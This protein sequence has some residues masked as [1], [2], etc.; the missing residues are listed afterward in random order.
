MEHCAKHHIWQ[1]CCSCIRVAAT[2]HPDPRPTLRS[3]D[4]PTKDDLLD[5]DTMPNRANAAHF[6]EVWVWKSSVAAL[7]GVPTAAKCTKSTPWSPGRSSPNLPEISPRMQATTPI[8]GS[9]SVT[10]D[11]M[12][13]LGRAIDKGG[14][15]MLRRFKLEELD[16]ITGKGV[17]AVARPLIKCCPKLKRINL[18]TTCRDSECGEVV[19]GMARSAGRARK[20]GVVFPGQ[21]Y[22][23]DE[24]HIHDTDDDED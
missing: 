17:G 8:G 10:D 4:P 20:I 13:V 18:G 21:Q 19:L 22:D 16:G 3:C 9:E 2:R 5:T 15:S 1:A 23:T 6:R 24:E 12:I 14:L 7:E 11:G